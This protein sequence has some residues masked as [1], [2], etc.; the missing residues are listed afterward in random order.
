VAMGGLAPHASRRRARASLQEMRHPA[1]SRHSRWGSWL[2]GSAGVRYTSPFALAGGKNPRPDVLRFG[3]APAP[4]R[5]GPPSRRPIRP[6]R[7]AVSRLFAQ[8][9]KRDLARHENREI[10][11]VL[12]RGGWSHN[13]EFEA[14]KR[15]SFCELTPPQ[16]LHFRLPPPSATYASRGSMQLPKAA[17]KLMEDM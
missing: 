14:Q 6:K 3:A 5:A 17:L 12:E 10:T 13:S 16:F 1:G 9:V 7:A 4:R 8:N 15:P 11:G 2:G